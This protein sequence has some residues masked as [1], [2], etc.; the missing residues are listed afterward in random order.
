MLAIVFSLAIEVSVYTC[1]H[2]NNKKFVQSLNVECPP[3]GTDTYF[4][5]YKSKEIWRCT[6]VW[7]G[8]RDR[9]LNY[10]IKYEK[11]TFSHLLAAG[12]CERCRWKM[13]DEE[14]DLSMNLARFGT[15]ANVINEDF[16]QSLEQMNNDPKS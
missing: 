14:L 2:L 6:L 15:M 16:I 4:Q 3:V 7:P 10:L 5:P 11:W 13:T 8:T 1:L 12:D 9:C